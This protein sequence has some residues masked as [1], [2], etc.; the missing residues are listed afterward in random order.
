MASS[1]TIHG[2]KGDFHGL[3]TSKRA[4]CL[5]HRKVVVYKQKGEV[6]LPGSDR[7][8]G[9]DVTKRHGH[10]A[11]WSLDNTGFRHGDFYAYVRGTDDCKGDFTKT[12]S[13]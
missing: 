7:D 6:Q 8:V 4:S 9:I 5:G 11:R 2:D 12:I 3:V 10:H 13:I 1:V